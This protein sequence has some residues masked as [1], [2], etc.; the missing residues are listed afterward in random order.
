MPVA[1]IDSFCNFIAGWKSF[2]PRRNA[3]T[4]AIPG[5]RM[6]RWGCTVRKQKILEYNANNNYYILNSFQDLF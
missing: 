3:K 4:R 6:P 1:L 2:F 5:S